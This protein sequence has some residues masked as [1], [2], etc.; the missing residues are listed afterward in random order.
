[1]SDINWK[2]IFGSI[3]AIALVLVVVCFVF[4]SW[5]T[6]ESTERGVQLTNGAVKGIAEPGLHFK[7]P[8]FQDVEKISIKAQHA[9]YPTITAYSND[10]QAANI[11][12]SVNWHIDP[13]AVA[14]I[15]KRF[16][17]SMDA[18]KHALV[19]PNVPQAIE[20]TLGQYT[21]IRAVQDRLSLVADVNKAVRATAGNQVVIDAVYVENTDFSDAYDQSI[22]RRMQAEVAI[23]TRRQNKQTE[24][25]E[26]EIK[27]IKA[28]AEA[29]SQLAVATAH[30]KAVKLQGEADAY[31]IE[32][33]GEA[34][35]NN[36]QIV[37]L[38]TAQNWK[39]ILP[40]TMVPGGAVPF[41]NVNPR[42]G[43][44]Q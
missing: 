21:A 19:D 8:V 3:A 1:M 22:E 27:V 28:N 10:S 12:V 9:S 23:Q 40:T 5:Y 26:A 20:D 42:A 24:E 33:K 13:G 31:A 36:P 2:G 39:G 7:L 43:A 18:V 14:I 6:I 38:I 17:T 30:A 25:V 15:Y 16:G 35:R 32:K 34:I 44:V 4:G 37:A 11:R 41:V 29:E